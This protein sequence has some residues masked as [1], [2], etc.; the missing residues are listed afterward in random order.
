MAKAAWG[1]K[2]ICA[3]CGSKY[4]DLQKE[5]IFC[6]KCGSEFINVSLQISSKTKM[7]APKKRVAPEVKGV[8]ARI[9]EDQGETGETPF[10]NVDSDDEKLDQE[11]SQIINNATDFS[12]ESEE[13]LNIAENVN[14]ESKKDEI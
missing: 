7:A 6:P 8:K 2:R 13:L 14:E 11:A 1:E 3:N 12:E 9:I 4:Y 5:P 10:D